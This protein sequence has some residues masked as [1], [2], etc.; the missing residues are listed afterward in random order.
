MST[1]LF[2]LAWATCSAGLSTT[3]HFERC[4]YGPLGHKLFFDEI[5]S[6]SG[7]ETRRR[8]DNIGDPLSIAFALCVF[9]E[10]TEPRS[11]QDFAARGLLNLLIPY[12]RQRWGICSRTC[13]PFRSIMSGRRLLQIGRNGQLT[14]R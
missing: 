10:V 11:E 12:F 3:A 9:A 5:F 6:K 4:G 7:T 14:L 1:I 2:F 13:R 8:S